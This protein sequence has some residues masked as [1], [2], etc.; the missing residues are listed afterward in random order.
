ML[1]EVYHSFMLFYTSIG[2]NFILF[3]GHPNGQN[4]IRWL[5]NI[6]FHVEPATWDGSK[7]S[8]SWFNRAPDQRSLGTFLYINR[9]V[10]YPLSAPNLIPREAYLVDFMI[11]RTLF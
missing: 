3:C 4:N 7:R 1:S 5:V 8:R 11:L 6:S 2:Y 9:T 10:D